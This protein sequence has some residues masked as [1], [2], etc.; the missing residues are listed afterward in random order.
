M[1]RLLQKVGLFTFGLIMVLLGVY[2][3]VWKLFAIPILTAVDKY[4][5]NALGGMDIILTIIICSFAAPVT[6]TFAW[7][8][9]AIM[10]CGVDL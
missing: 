5:H 1:K 8:G 4:D 10:A 6:S 7:G 9:I 2:F 3:G